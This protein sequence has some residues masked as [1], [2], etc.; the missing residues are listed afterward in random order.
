MRVLLA[1]N[2]YVHRGGEDAVF[3]QEGALLREHG[4][5]VVEFVRDN[6]DLKQTDAR[7]ALDTVWSSRSRKDVERAMRELKPDILHVH[8]TLPQISPSIYY[9]AAACKVPVV[10]TLHNYRLLCANGML[11]RDGGVCEDCVGRTFGFPAVVHRCYRDD[12]LAS[13]SVVSTV[14]VHRVM[15]TWRNKVT[16]Y[17]ALCEFARTKMLEAGLRPERVVVKPNFSRDRHVGVDLDRPRSGALYLGRLSVE[18]GVGVLIDAWK[19]LDVPINVV[20]TGPLEAATRAAAGAQVTMHGFL[21]D[22]DVTGAMRQSSF[23][24]MPSIVYEGFPMVVAEAYAAGA[25]IVASRL[26]ALAELVEDG[27]TGLHFNPGDPDDLAEK[28]RWAHA[29]PA[30]MA[31]MGRNARLRYERS[32]TPEVNYERLIEIYDEARAAVPT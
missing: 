28:V 29:H 9:A 13:F 21:G 31:A 10:Q 17:I 12:R 6:R 7:M 19:T 3:D 16:R 25:P 2:R 30:E 4:H 24:V 5:E 15:G 18:K 27:V 11:M 26:G 20:G 1:H 32:Y 23:L 22:E 8:N 14:A